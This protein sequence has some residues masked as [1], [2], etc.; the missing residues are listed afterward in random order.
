MY[1]YSN[2]NIQMQI[3]YDDL[4]KRNPGVVFFEEMT[5]V[6]QELKALGWRDESPLNKHQIEGFN[7][8]KDSR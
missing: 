6:Y 3:Q 1:A 7:S 5:D 4:S 2:E 8:P